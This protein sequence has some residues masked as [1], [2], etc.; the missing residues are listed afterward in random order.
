MN[1]KITTE[2]IEEIKNLLQKGY[3]IK[4]IAQ[5]LNCNDGRIYRCARK[6]GLKLNDY[7]TRKYSIYVPSEQTII[8]TIKVN[9]KRLEIV[10]MYNRGMTFEE[11]GQH[12]GCSRQYIHQL[13][14]LK[15]SKREV[16]E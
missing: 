14:K 11:I 4:N 5:E 16:E 2:S 3:S 13:M 8:N 15:K 1:A 6:G 9:E 10:R 12:F 7:K